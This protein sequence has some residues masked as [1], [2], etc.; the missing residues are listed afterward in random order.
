MFYRSIKNKSVLSLVCLLLFAYQ[1]MAQNETLTSGLNVY[2][3]SYEER[4]DWS[5]NYGGNDGGSSLEDYTQETLTAANATFS[6]C[7]HGYQCVEVG[8][9]ERSK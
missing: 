4:F 9:K 6:Y 2:I 5:L 7:T 1:A 8:A 3:P